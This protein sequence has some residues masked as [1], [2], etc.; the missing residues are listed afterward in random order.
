MQFHEYISSFDEF[1][2]AAKAYGV[3]DPQRKDEL[4]F[5]KESISSLGELKNRGII[6]SDQVAI[7]LNQLIVEHK[8]FISRKPYYNIYPSIIKMLLELDIDNLNCEHIPFECVPYFPFIIKFPVMNNPFTISGKSVEYIVCDYSPA[9]KEILQDLKLERSP[10]HDLFQMWVFHGEISEKGDE[11]TFERRVLTFE[12]L[13]IIDGYSV[14]EMMER[15]IRERESVDLEKGD[16]VT[17]DDLNNIVRLSI[18][19]VMLSG[20]NELISPDVLSKLQ[21]DFDRTKDQKY[22]EKSHR[23]GKIGFNIGKELESGLTL[24]RSGTVIPHLRRAH[25]AHVPYGKGR[26]KRKLILRRGSIVHR[27]IVKKVPTGFEETEKE[28]SSGDK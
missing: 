2:K 6:N 13:D 4:E 5:C 24:K 10:T 20:D 9:G 7:S 16:K 23:K 14:T 17:R 22:V 27:E 8:L 18:G 26:L 1:K 28:E 11:N 12:N 3:K 15:I 21:G 19:V 25:L